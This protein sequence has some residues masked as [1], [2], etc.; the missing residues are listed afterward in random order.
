MAPT[1]T[2]HLTTRRAER[3][4][5]N[6]KFSRLIA[7]LEIWTHLSSVLSGTPGPGLWSLDQSLEREVCVRR[8]LCFRIPNAR[9]ASNWLVMIYS[10]HQIADC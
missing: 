8:Q 7:S 4:E 9:D 6:S 1:C 3:I 10:G 2:P 5:A